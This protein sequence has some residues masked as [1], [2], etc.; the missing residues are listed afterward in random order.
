MIYFFVLVTF[1]SCSTSDNENSHHLSFY[2]KNYSYQDKAGSFSLK[3]QSG[4]DVN[5]NLVTKYRLSGGKKVLEQSIVF[6]KV[7]K[8]KKKLPILVPISSQYN[9]WFDKRK[10]QSRMKLSENKKQL[11]VTLTSPEDQWNGSKSYDISDN[12]GVICFYTQVLECAKRIGFL[13]RSIRSRSGAMTFTLIWDGYPYIQEQYGGLGDKPFTKASLRYDEK[14]SDGG[15]RF[16]L[17]F[18]NSI[19]FYFVDQNNHF[20]RMFWPAQGVSVLKAD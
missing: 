5:K 18:N 4:L 7:T 6:S 3:R 12:N 1:L 8:L 11:T 20:E 9:V 15:I 13:E 2:S 17:S 16:K 14:T 19:V 10:Y